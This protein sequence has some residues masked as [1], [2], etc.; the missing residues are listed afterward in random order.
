MISRVIY[1]ALC[2]IGVALVSLSTIQTSTDQTPVS[3]SAI[4]MCLGLPTCIAWFSIY[5]KVVGNGWA[6][7]IERTCMLTGLIGIANL[8]LLPPIL[9]CGYLGWIEAAWPHNMLQLDY[10]LVEA[11][12]ATGYNFSF[13]GCTSL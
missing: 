9:L 1:V 4:L 8:F 2:I 13:M 12:A 5:F 7:N 6:T 11:V 3:L 10:F